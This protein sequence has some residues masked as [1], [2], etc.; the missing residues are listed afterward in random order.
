MSVESLPSADLP[1]A[2]ARDVALGH[3]AAFEQRGLGACLRRI[4]QW[5][6]LKPSARADL[7]AELSQELA[8]DCLENADEIAGLGEEGCFRRFAAAVH[9]HHYRLRVRDQRLRVATERAPEPRVPPPSLVVAELEAETIPRLLQGAEHLRNGRLCAR[10]TQLALGVGR[11]TFQRILERAADAGGLDHDQVEFWRRRLVEALCMV[12]A[13]RI[14]ADG[15][16][17]LWND[18]AR[19]D[20]HAEAFRARLAGIRSA[21]CA[22]PLDPE[23]RAV[24][25][26]C[27]ANGR[28]IQDL[29]ARE[30]LALASRLDATDR[31]VLSWRFELEILDGDLLAAA[32]CLAQLRHRDHD[33]NR[34][35]LAR[36]RLLE[37]RGRI[38]TARALIRRAILRCRGTDPR[39][40]ACADALGPRTR[41]APSARQLT[42]SGRRADANR[43]PSALRTGS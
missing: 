5:S 32:R 34:L 22:R 7:V 6:I 37:A 14:R 15:A 20:F 9:R 31:D 39:L 17:R 29:P 8:V 43:A 24:L 36:A 25:T 27:A 28:R 21:L 35:A 13:A 18:D 2:S 26:A 1:P 11:R 10:S 16:A 41:A 4:R 3:L 19:R 38:D 23:V 42:R 40:A 12:A 30:L 33:R